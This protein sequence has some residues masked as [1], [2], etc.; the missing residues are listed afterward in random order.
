MHNKPEFSTKSHVHPICWLMFCPKT[1]Y[2]SC[3]RLDLNQSETTW[4]PFLGFLR[5]HG[6]PGFFG[7]QGKGEKPDFEV[8]RRSSDAFTLHVC[9]SNLPFPFSKS[10]LDRLLV[11][12]VTIRMKGTH[13]WLSRKR[14]TLILNWPA[15]SPFLQVRDS[16]ILWR[17]KKIANDHWS[18]YYL[19]T[20][21]ST[22]ERGHL[23]LEKLSSM[24]IFYLRRYHRKAGNI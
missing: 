3:L 15:G 11:L 19:H 7:G 20:W 17:A 8:K 24:D 2:D 12:L 1:R 6:H 22:K 18:L 21:R 16:Q 13:C 5:G 14:Q 10:S 9:T 23:M 4:H